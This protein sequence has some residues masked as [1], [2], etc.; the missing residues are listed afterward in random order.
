MVI[1]VRDIDDLTELGKIYIYIFFSKK[2]Y[3]S[4]QWKYTRTAINDMPSSS[5]S[6][7]GGVAGLI[8]VNTGG[9][10]LDRRAYQDRPG[11]RNPGQKGL[12][13]FLVE[14]PVKSELV[15]K[16][17]LQLPCTRA[18]L[19]LRVSNGS[20]L[21]ELSKKATLVLNAFR[22]Q[23]L[24]QEGTTALVSNICTQ[25]RALGASEI[26]SKFCLTTLC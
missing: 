17:C 8:H 25:T 11:V 23:F 14:T 20:S 26:K 24:L 6:Q 10:V 9:A 12:F 21:R 1:K 7:Q 3:D 5:G 2:I 19:L 18:F 13:N 4:G 15:T 22:A 16:P